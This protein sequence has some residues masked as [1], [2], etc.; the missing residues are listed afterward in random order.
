MGY[1][2]RPYNFTNDETDTIWN[3][4]IKPNLTNKNDCILYTSKTFSYKEKEYEVR[5]FA[6]EKYCKDDSTEVDYRG[7][8]F[9]STCHN[10]MCVNQNHIQNI[11][12]EWNSQEVLD[13]ILANSE[14][15]KPTEG[16]EKGCLVWKRYTYPNGYGLFEYN[17]IKYRAHVAAMFAS[18]NSPN[19]PVDENGQKLIV[20]H[21]C[22]NKTCCEYTHLEWG[23]YQQNNLDDTIRDGTTTRGKNA[24]ITKELAQEIKNSVTSGLTTTERAEKYGVS[25]GIVNKIDDG[26]S[27]SHLSGPKDEVVNKLVEERKDRKAKMAQELKQRGLNEEDY[28]IL[29]E[30]FQKKLEIKD[31]GCDTPCEEWTGATFRDGFPKILYNYRTFT[32]VPVACEIHH[33]KKPTEDSIVIHKCQNR[34]CMNKD[35]MSWGSAFD[36]KGK[37]K[38]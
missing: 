26:S 21:K 23:T 25:R 9:I 19:R 27:W 36:K 35:H 12:C 20:R 8:R 22:T 15:L 30:R 37:A 3:E 28:K 33:G 38:A 24:K 17:K 31:A 10:K 13:K 5:Q 11:L 16:Q 4:Q 34:L 7:K 2:P 14:R 6:Y 32:A 29:L 1:T 18:T